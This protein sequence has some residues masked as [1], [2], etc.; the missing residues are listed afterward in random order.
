VSKNF[1]Y[2]RSK[3]CPIVNVIS[4]DWNK[5]MTNNKGHN[6]TLNGQ[7]GTGKIFFGVKP[8]YKGHLREPENV[9]FMS[10]CSL[11]TG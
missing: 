8:T 6:V 11:H 3:A 7:C 9:A 1:L 5:K 2:A 4:S 10:S